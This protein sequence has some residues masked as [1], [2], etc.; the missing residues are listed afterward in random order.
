LNAFAQAESTRGHRKTSLKWCPSRLGFV[1]RVERRR[2]EDPMARFEGRELWSPCA[3]RRMMRPVASAGMGK[4][5][6]GLALGARKADE[7]QLRSQVLSQVELGKEGNMVAARGGTDDAPVD[8]KG[9]GP[10]VLRWK[11]LEGRRSAASGA[12]AFPSR[13]WERGGEG[14]LA[15][16]GS[17]RLE[18]RTTVT[19]RHLSDFVEGMLGGSR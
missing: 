11:R 12:S 13:T 8:S 18:G 9:G 4:R 10:K 1:E 6:Q 5:P 3:A 16:G 14:V 19:L 7:V 15:R 2:V 17:G